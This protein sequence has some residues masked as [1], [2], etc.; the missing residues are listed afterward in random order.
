ML[1]TMKLEHGNSDIKIILFGYS[2]VKEDIFDF[3]QTTHKLKSDVAKPFVDSTNKVVMG[4]GLKTESIPDIC[5]CAKRNCML[6]ENSEM[7]ITILVVRLGDLV[8]EQ[9]GV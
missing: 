2:R 5:N 9:V 8:L 4:Y 1:S 6:L 7:I 3:L